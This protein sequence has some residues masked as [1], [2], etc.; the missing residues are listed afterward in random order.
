MSEKSIEAIEEVRQKFAEVF[1]PILDDVGAEVYEAYAKF[2]N[3]VH[4]M[5][6]EYNSLVDEL[7]INIDERNE[8]VGEIEEL[9]EALRSLKEV[10]NNV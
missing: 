10:L 8:A 1:E 3:A 6:L 5:I 2:D 7:N 4:I 9:T